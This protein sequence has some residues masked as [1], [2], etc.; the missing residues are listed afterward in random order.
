M[1]IKFDHVRD[2]NIF[3]TVCTYMIA[4]VLSSGF[5]IMFMTA[6]TSERT[7]CLAPPPQKK[8]KTV[9]PQKFY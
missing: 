9:T 4:R 5:K 7:N 8:I 1:K 6:V 3:M 2:K